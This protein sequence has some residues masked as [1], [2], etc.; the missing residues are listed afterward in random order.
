MTMR[1]ESFFFRTS[2]DAFIAVDMNIYLP[3]AMNQRM[4]MRKPYHCLEWLHSKL[5]TPINP[6]QV[7][8]H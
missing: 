8:I 2:T 5:G 7:G 1:N 4:R 6:C 3:N